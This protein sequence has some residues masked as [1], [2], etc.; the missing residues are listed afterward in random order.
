MTQENKD[1][2]NIKKRVEELA[3]CCSAGSMM[4]QCL[5]IILGSAERMATEINRLKDDLEGSEHFH[6][7]EITKLKD[8]Y[9]VALELVEA[10]KPITCGECKFW[11]I[12]YQICD[13]DPRKMRDTNGNESG[14]CHHAVRKEVSDGK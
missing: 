3:E 13:T 12:H 1:L 14:F 6:K 2:E 8:G 10:A 9:K 7:A 11:N 4:R 5:G